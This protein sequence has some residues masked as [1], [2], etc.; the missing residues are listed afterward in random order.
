MEVSEISFLR[1]KVVEPE[2]FVIEGKSFLEKMRHTSCFDLVRRIKAFINAFTEMEGKHNPDQFSSKLQGFLDEINLVIQDHSQWRDEDEVGIKKAMEAL[3]RYLLTRLYSTAFYLPTSTD[4]ED[5]ES[6]YYRVRLLQFLQPDHLDLPK[7][8]Y[9]QIAFE[10]AAQEFSR[11]EEDLLKSPREKLACII[12]AVKIVINLL[13]YSTSDGGTGADDF[14]PYIIYLILLT[15]PKHIH[16]NLRYIRRFRRPTSMTSEEAYYLTQVE[17][18]V[19][20]ISTLDHTSL[21]ITEEEFKRGMSEAEDK[22]KNGRDVPRR[23]SK[24]Q[25]GWERLLVDLAATNPSFKERDEVLSPLQ[26]EEK[27]LDESKGPRLPTINDSIGFPQSENFE[28]EEE[29]EGEEE[30]EEEEVKEMVDTATSDKMEGSSISRG[31]LL[32]A[33]I[34]DCLLPK[35][36]QKKFEDMTVSELKELHNCYKTLGSR[37]EGLKEERPS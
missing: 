32:M 11:L 9:N 22:I 25:G 6:F 34:S 37:L 24:E 5:D 3:E 2:V 33:T 4:A 21:S 23:F 16:S 7:R 13:K 12:N 14:L 8:K 36:L 28:D 18:G 1:N 35:L 15:S 17:S 31:Q 19:M 10:M 29:R 30:E 27:E 20:F 26:E